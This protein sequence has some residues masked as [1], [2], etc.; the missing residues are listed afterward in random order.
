VLCTYF[1]ILCFLYANLSYPIIANPFGDTALIPL[2]LVVVAYMYAMEQFGMW[3]ADR[4]GLWRRVKNDLLKDVRSAAADLDALKSVDFDDELQFTAR[5]QSDIFRT[6]FMEANKH[7]IFQTLDRIITP[8][9]VTEIR[10]YLMNV[11]AGLINMENVS[12]PA[13]EGGTSGA[14]TDGESAVARKK[15]DDISDD[16]DDEA[17]PMKNAAWQLPELSIRTTQIAQQWITRGRSAL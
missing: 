9:T 14:L 3:L 7:W 12:G 2:V 13:G 5:V 11:Y 16:D 1:A 4:V 8:R 17:N 6:R 10:P 15:R